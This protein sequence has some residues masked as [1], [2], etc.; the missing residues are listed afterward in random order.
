MKGFKPKKLKFKSKSK[1]EIN[2]KTIII[3]IVAALLVAV[4]IVGAVIA[5]SITNQLE[6][7]VGIYLAKAPDKI[8]Y[9]QNDAPNYDGIVIMAQLLNGETYQIPIEECTITGFDSSKVTDSCRVK[10]AYQNFSTYFTVIIN[11]PPKGT[12]IP[13]NVSFEALPQTEYKVGDQ[14][15]TEGGIIVVEFSDGST[16]RLAMMNRYVISG[17]NT[18][19]PGTYEVTVRYQQNGVSVY[20]TYTI[21]V[22]E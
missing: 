7:V 16:V 21:T 8:S 9:Y 19:A 6:Q 11:E 4:L 22:T 12:L 15:N 14:L 10:V 18:D 2:K 1:K 20:T 3:A 5:T 13:V 17:F